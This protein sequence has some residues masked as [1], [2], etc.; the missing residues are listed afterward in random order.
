MITWSVWGL[1]DILIN[2]E[3]STLLHSFRIYDKITDDN[4]K[5][6]R[7]L[8]RP[9]CWKQDERRI[10]KKRNK[11]TWSSKGGSISQIFIPTTPLVG[12]ARDL[13]EIAGKE[14]LLGLK[15]KIVEMGEGKIKNELQR[16]NPTGSPG[17]SN[18]DCLACLERWGQGGNCV[19]TNV[20]YEL[21]WW[22]CPLD[23]ECVYVGEY[24]RNLYT[25]GKEH[26]EKYRSNKRNKDSFIKKHED[27]K[28]DG[29][30][31]DFT[32]KVTGIFRDCLSRQ[33]SEG[34]YI[35]WCDKNIL[36]GKSEWHPD[37]QK[38]FTKRPL[39]AE[40]KRLQYCS[41]LVAEGLKLSA[42][43]VVPTPLCCVQNE[44]AM[45][46]TLY[47]FGCGIWRE[48]GLGFGKNGVT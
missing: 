37:M 39:V 21:K 43:L 36:N 6:I 19:K 33:V 32:A 14:A 22:L 1:L 41:I 16:P 13:R 20:Q 45:E 47:G 7:P 18:V 9:R 46:W 27:E 2:T 29:R 12:L 4:Q 44:V 11:Y 42:C 34:V 26:I 38:G 40:Q 28:H 25:K 3:L 5:G 35:R 15:F 24:A 8:Y 30:P 10:N 23:D 31:A 48:V 17:C